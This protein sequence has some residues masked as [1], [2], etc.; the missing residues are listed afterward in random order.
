[1]F[2]DFYSNIDKI[3]FNS[4]ELRRYFDKL[5]TELIKCFYDLPRDTDCFLGGEHYFGGRDWNSGTYWRVSLSE[6]IRYSDDIFLSKIR[7][8]K[9]K[10]LYS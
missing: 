9:K 3:R 5:Q 6:I 10:E 7:D 8:K 2:D 4:V 1:M